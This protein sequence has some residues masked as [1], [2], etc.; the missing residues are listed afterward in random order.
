MN[1]Q[2]AISTMRA[3]RRGQLSA[4]VIGTLALLAAGSSLAQDG[5]ATDANSGQATEAAAQ[6]TTS[7][8]T[9]T[10]DLDRILVTANKREENIRDVP[11]SIS[12][13]GSE[14]LERIN[15]T[16]LSD[17]ANYIPGFQ[18]NSGGTPGQTTVSMRGIAPLS[19]GSTIGT[20]LDETPVGSSGI[21]QAATLFALDLLPYD[22]DRVEVLRGPQGTLYGAGAMGGLVKYVTKQPDLNES[23]LRVG[24]GVSTIEGGDDLGSNARFGINLPLVE[25]RAALR[26]SYA[27]NYLPGY[28][29]NT[30]NGRE[31]IN[32]GL[33]T[34]G[35]LAFLWQGDAF[36]LKLAAMQQTIDSDNNGAMNLETDS[37]EPLNGDLEHAVYVN[38]PFTK[39][40]DYYTATLD[41]DLGWGD[42]T[43]ATGYSET[44]TNRLTDSTIPY[45]NFADLALG[46]P[47]PGSS[48]FNIGL[49]L[50]KFTQEF[51]LTSKSDTAFE[52]QVGV[53][54]T[55]EEAF[56]SQGIYLNQLDGSPLPPPYDAL[57]GTLAYLEI[58]SDYKE[59]A[60]FANGSYQFTDRFKLGAGIRYSQNDQTFGQN[61]LSGALLPIENVSGSSSEDV[62]T[63]SVTPQFDLTD[64][65]M[66]YGKI[67]TGYQPGGPN[68]KVA[69]LPPQVDSSMLTSYEIGLKSLF[70]D[71]RVT[72]DIAAFQ[73]D[74]EDI[75]VPTSYNGVSGL[76]NGGTATTQGVEVSTMFRPTTDF[77]LG[78]NFAYTDAALTEDYPTVY[79]ASDPYV[80]EVTGGLDGD[81]LPY[82]P[83]LSGA[84]TADYFFPLGSWEGSLGGGLRYTDDRVSDT[85]NLQEITDPSTTPPTVLQ[86][87]L[88][89]PNSLDSYF[90]MDLYA[91]ISNEHWT[92]RAYLK[93]ATDE[94]AY[95]SIGNDVNQ[96][97][98]ATNSRT[99]VPILPRTFGLEF[100]YKF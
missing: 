80:V 98:G 63:W 72:L 9:S 34:S 22:I 40:L 53:F 93:N 71:N 59:T 8:S 49:D 37:L 82:V 19:S 65:S 99:G 30:V 17:F 6:E 94:R 55:K 41:W 44:A 96:V 3:M 46:L 26:A 85:T 78:F 43:S 76:V 60:L 29:D 56:Q 20:Y 51:R 52:W 69:G 38:E 70:A 15:A 11:A 88:S 1:Q 2:Q 25:D 31:D 36:S 84:L 57:F 21:Y 61:V 100:D 87:T 77:Q 47:D 4:A 24:A 73:I 66:L 64:T 28:I 5:A 32:G 92:M 18:L 39:K 97:T 14:Q 12:V 10:T 86:S 81:K 33:Q 35:R 74:W 68:V 27:R 89:P 23:E 48:Y 58:P 7:K 67:A 50:D 95:S 91:A 13:I 90:A 62:F 79:I 83:E 42:F 54:Y 45:G 16:Q 75:Q